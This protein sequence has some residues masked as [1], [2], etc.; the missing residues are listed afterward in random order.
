MEKVLAKLESKD[1][2]RNIIIEISSDIFMLIIGLV[3]G[4]FLKVWLM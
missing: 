2:I 3:M 4:Y 1:F